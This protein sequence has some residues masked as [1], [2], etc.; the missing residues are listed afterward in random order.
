MFAEGRALG[1]EGL[2]IAEEVAHPG[3]L[4]I[5]SLGLGMLALRQGDLPSALSLLE[6]VMD[7]CHEADLPT[8][9]PHIAAALGAAYTLGGRVA[10]AVPLITPAM[11]QA[12]AVE[13]VV[14][15]ALC[16]LALGE[17]QLRASRVEEAQ[18]LAE[19][20]LALARARQERGIQ[21]YALRLLGEMAVRRE[22]PESTKAGEYY[23]QALALAEELGMR[24]LVAH[25]HRGLGRLY[26]TTGQHKQARA[27]LSTAIDLYR[28][29]EMTFWLP[30]AEAVLV[31]MEER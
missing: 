20:A 11:A 9:F 5:A 18:A 30:E 31:Q 21:A 3:S 26:A 23:H 16:R 6:R 27:A 12:S 14:Y 25:C 4:M 29:M 10:D 7:I 19:Q 1:E 22:P 2:Q 8:Y 13:G 15:Q 24:P 17:A 28:T